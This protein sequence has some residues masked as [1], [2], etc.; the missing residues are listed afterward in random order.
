M[1]DAGLCLP[2]VTA[3]AVV[4]LSSVLSH[5]LCARGYK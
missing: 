2:V 3:G 4:L 1:Y 5:A